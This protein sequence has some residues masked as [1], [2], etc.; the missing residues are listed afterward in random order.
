MDITP[1]LPV[2]LISKYQ[3]YIGILRWAVELGRID[4][5]YEVSRL[6][7]FNAQ[8]R[9]GNLKTVLRLSHISRSI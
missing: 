5:L 2:K 6:S 8:P 9:E 7:S 4:I 3:S 1:L